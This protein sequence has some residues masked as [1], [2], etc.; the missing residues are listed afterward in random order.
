MLRPDE[1]FIFVSYSRK[2]EDIVDHEV[3]RIE[4][5]GCN[6]WQDKRELIAGN[7]W[8]P[9]IRKAIEACAC[10]VVFITRASVQSPRV[11]KEIGDALAADKVVI[12]IQWEDV[13]W[14]D[15]FRDMI[16]GI[17][18]IQ[19]YC[20]TTP[21]YEELLSRA[22]SKYNTCIKSRPEERKEPS[23]VKRVLTAADPP[24]NISWK[25]I[26][27]VLVLLAGFFF[28][29]GLAA[30][31]THFFATDDPRDPLNNRLAAY[32][33]GSFFTVISAG[34]GGGA[35]FVH[36]KYLRRKNV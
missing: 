11:E 8:E 31:G 18:A 27:F 12:W 17:Q 2:D 23:D 20:L 3:Q 22:V 9:D 4:S 35:F 33:V 32:L 16:T 26:Y 28:L 24:S 5:Q 13:E 1:P 15:R 6:A 7:L 10:F 25:V 21:K 34:M 14:P 19:R 30:M 29:F 36:R